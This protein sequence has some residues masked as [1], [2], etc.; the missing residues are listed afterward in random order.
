MIHINIGSNLNS[1]NGSKFENISIATKLLINFGLNIKK[2][3]SFYETPS[4]P[5]N[6]LPRFI[7]IGLIGEYKFGCTK[8][9]KNI[10]LIEKRLGR[11]KSKKNDPRICDIDIIDFNQIVQN[12]NLLTLPHPRLHRRNFVLYPIREIDPQWVHPILKKNVDFLIDELSQNSRIEITRLNKSVI[13]H[14]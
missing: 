9:L 1:K 8:L 7:N 4:Y 3:S 13:I 2:I 6:S 11:T 10:S 5:N 14:R 12:T